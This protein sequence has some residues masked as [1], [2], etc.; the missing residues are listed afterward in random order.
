[1]GKFEFEAFDKYS[2]RIDRLSGNQLDSLNRKS[3]N[4]IASK[5]ISD[6]VPLTP[7]GEYANGSGRVGGTLRRGWTIDGRA[8]KRGLDYE[9]DVIN[10][11]EYALT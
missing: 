4:L 8:K 2:K 5:Y 1:M 3:V 10:P 7:V 6:V 11:T 9:V